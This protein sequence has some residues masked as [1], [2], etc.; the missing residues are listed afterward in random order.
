MNFLISLFIFLVFTSVIEADRWTSSLR[1]AETVALPTP[2][3]TDKDVIPYSS[4]STDQ[5]PQSWAYQQ[6]R[7]SNNQF[8]NTWKIIK[9]V[10]IKPISP[11]SA[12]IHYIALV[13]FDIAR[14]PKVFRYDELYKYFKETMSPFLRWCSQ[15]NVNEQ[16]SSVILLREI[17]RLYENLI[18]YDGNNPQSLQPESVQQICHRIVDKSDK[19]A[20]VCSIP[21]FKSL[22]KEIWGKRKKYKELVKLNERS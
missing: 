14:T 21:I 6:I 20:S 16:I 19:S 3:V 18:N 10:R 13:M 22:I 12:L 5:F 1:N 7:R 9:N 2:D 8:P 15:L 11:F 4:F 17:Q